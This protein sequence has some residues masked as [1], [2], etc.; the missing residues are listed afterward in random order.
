MLTM[1]GDDGEEQLHAN[2][3][4]TRCWSRMWSGWRLGTATAEWAD[5]AETVAVASHPLHDNVLWSAWPFVFLFLV[6][7]LPVLLLFLR[8]VL[9]VPCLGPPLPVL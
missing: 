3:S 2:E 5:G 9:L 7:Y 4:S 6:F 1:R 8:L